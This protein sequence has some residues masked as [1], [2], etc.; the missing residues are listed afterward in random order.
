MFKAAST[1]TSHTTSS[2]FAPQDSYVCKKYS[3][4]YAKAILKELSEL[5]FN[6][7]IIINA[8][9]INLNKSTIILDEIKKVMVGFC[10]IIINKQIAP[11]DHS[12][13]VKQMF[14]FWEQLSNTFNSYIR[15]LLQFESA[16]A[17]HEILSKKTRE[18]TDM[19]DKDK[20]EKMELERQ[21]AYF[22][23]QANMYFRKFMDLSSSYAGV[24]Q[25]TTPYVITPEQ[26]IKVFNFPCF[27]ETGKKQKFEL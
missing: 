7:I 1:E 19:E 22:N 16:S 11:L 24:C 8:G 3:E 2:E 5:V 20:R 26:V 21:L 4:D 6:L 27:K 14:N 13:A 18:F 12:L 17:K 9:E 25:S 15:E 10:P 23:S